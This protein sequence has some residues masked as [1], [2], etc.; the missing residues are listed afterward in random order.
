MACEAFTG[1]LGEIVAERVIAGVASMLL[2]IGSA[3]ADAS[4]GASGADASVGDAPAGAWIGNAGAGALVGNSGAAGMIGSAAAGALVG[5][6]GPAGLVGNAAAGALGDGARVDSVYARAGVP[7]LWSTEGRPTAQASELIALLNDVEAF[8][9]R[10]QDYGVDSITAAA[11]GLGASSEPRAISDFDRALTAAT[12]RLLSDLHYGRV[13]PRRAGFELPEPR[14]DLDLPAAVAGLATAPSVA[15]AVAAVEPPFYHYVLL[16]LALSRYRELAADPAL[17]RLPPLDRRSLKFGDHYAGA[18]ALR[19]LLLGEGDLPADADAPGDATLLDA[20]LV[21]GLAHFQ[22]RHGL[23]TDGSLGASTYA[24]LTVPLSA[25]V[26]QIELTLERWRWLPVPDSP[27]IIVNIPEFRL[28]AFDTTADFADSIVQIP[29]I[30]GETNPAKRTPVFVGEMK[31]VVFRPYWDV[32]HDIVVREMIP[33]IAAHPEYLVRNHLEIVRGETDDALP[34]DPSPDNVAALARGELR[35]RQLPGDDNSL[36]LIK[37]LFP[38]IHDVY[39]HSTPARGLFQAS[40]RAFSHGCIRV[41]DPVGLAEFVLRNAPGEWPR[42]AIEA[43]M[44]NGKNDQRVAL[45]RPIPVMILYGTVIA[46]EAGPV[47]FFDDIYGHDRRLA[48]LL[49]LAP[50]VRSAALR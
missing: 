12:W 4:V 47:Q 19:R 42:A 10:P 29:V 16:K 11:A 41:Q 44:Q 28:F 26:R 2:I 40:R 23:S 34:V 33:K 17:T 50:P 21:A 38:N 25:R 7:L 9:L 30:V 43:A 18:P 31:T 46:T 36:G 14:R 5:N 22:R 27:P 37:F 13:D 32:P 1:G 20:A 35:L 8:G 49:G 3:A 45:E 48:D 15:D 24:A 6:A 39:L